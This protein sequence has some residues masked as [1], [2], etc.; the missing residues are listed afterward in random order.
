VH[1]IISDDGTKRTLYQVFHHLV[2]AP[3][4]AFAAWWARHDDALSTLFALHEL[5]RVISRKVDLIAGG[6][7]SSARIFGTTVAVR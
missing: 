7:S 4:V 5:G 6:V 1:N 3:V 2:S